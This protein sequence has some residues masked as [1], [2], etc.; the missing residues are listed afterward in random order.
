M[1]PVAVVMI[2]FMYTMSLGF[3]LAEEV[4][5][6]PA[7]IE[8][9]SLNGTAISP[10]EFVESTSPAFTEAGRQALVPP[11]DGGSLFDRALNFSQNGFSAVW[12]LLGLL[13]GTCFMQ[14]LYF[15][16]IPTALVTVFQLIFG[17]V[18][19]RTVVYYVLGR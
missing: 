1:R 2:G 18:A 10:R 8:V 16:G 15:F 9:R 19:V 3:Y 12:T 11:Q 4:F 7:G 17:F 6:V 14:F 5:L 13:S